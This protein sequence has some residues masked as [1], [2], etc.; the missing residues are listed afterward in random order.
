VAEI[1]PFR[2]LRYDEAKAGRL[3][4][5][6]CPPYD[7]IAEDLRGELYAKSP[8]NF[9]RV[10]YA[11]DE[12]N[13]DRYR[14]ASRSLAEWTEHGILRRD[15]KAAF[16]GY[17]HVF[18]FRG[19]KYLRRGFFCALR[20]S[21]T[22]EGIV[23]PHELT[24]PKPK[25]DRLELLRRTR[26]NTSAVFG[27]YPDDDGVVAALLARGRKHAVGDARLG[28]ERHTVWTL[29]DDG[30]AGELR[31]RLR[32]ARIYIAD[33]HHRYETALDYRA[34]DKSEG[35]KYVLAYL[36]ALNDPGL[37]ILAT[38]RVVQGDG[39]LE[40]AA[41]RW[42]VR[43]PIDA[44]A[45]ADTQP[46]IALARDGRVTELAVRPDAD[47]SALPPVWRTLP[48]AQAEELLLR[49]VRE[50]GAKIAYEHDTA[51]AMDAAKGGATA[52]LLR[53]VD[54]QTLRRVADAG[55]R[56]PQKTTYF[57]PKVAAGL[58]IRSLGD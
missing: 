44:G 30:V 7:V 26:T 52:V 38:H 56:L 9:V 40:S 20:L 53:P 1:R 10:E 45:L 17:D 57:Y 22:G 41:D 34:E 6:I 21:P 19:K 12:P 43:S 16:Y 50:S 13:E 24:F 58:V 23:R 2:A 54:A 25:L 3:A 46:G 33:G 14:V 47:L 51:R 32:S 18:T 31:D 49:E 27:M 15:A 48:V 42:F 28:D 39:A 36:S 35:A 4:D 5:Q 8:Y 37:L 11:R 29:D 55:D